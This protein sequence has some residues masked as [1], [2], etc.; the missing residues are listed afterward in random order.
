[1]K[2]LSIHQLGTD[3]QGVILDADPSSPEP[4]HFRVVIP[5]GDVDIVRTT[6]GDF[7]VHIR[8][9]SEE[10]LLARNVPV[11]KICD[12]RVDIKGKHA[13]ECNAGDLGHPDLYHAAL[14]VTKKGGQTQ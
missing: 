9:N 4:I 13:A 6:D 5:G 11:G 1:M 12:A 8:V 2:K 10:D 3:V 7:W 14:R